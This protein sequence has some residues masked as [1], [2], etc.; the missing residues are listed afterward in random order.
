MA[1]LDDQQ[2][3]ESAS[4]AFANDAL[5]LTIL[6]TERC[7]LRCTYCYERFE[8]GK[9]SGEVVESVKRLLSRRV[10]E[11]RRLAV[12]WF[13]GE[14]LLAM[15]VIEQIS[16]H[17]QRLADQHPDLDYG[18]S[19]TTNGVR[20]SVDVA[21][22]LADVGVRQ[23][24]VSLDGPAE[25][26]DLTRKL[27]GG[28]GSYAQ[29]ERNLLGI[30]DSDIP[31]EISLRVHVTIANVDR[32]ADFTEDLIAKFLGDERFSVYFFPI[33]DLGG[34]NQGDFA[35]L[36][37]ATAT[38][39]VHRLTK[40]VN[41]AR[42]KSALKAKKK[43]CAAHYVCYA[44]KPNAWV[45]RSDGRLAKCTVGFEDE[46]NHIGR[47]LPDGTLDVLTERTRIWLRG[48]STGDA[49]SLQCPYEDMRE[50]VQLG[51]VVSRR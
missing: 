16:G 5:E 2:F 1:V 39:V 7:N 47:L 26:H 8:L 34:P 27:A 23:L 17:A 31:V 13:G 37:Q 50:D 12:D 20:L 40:R 10:P 9:M 11:L 14:P 25:V 51:R 36:D 28:S 30:R 44:A 48:W 43:G 33:V 45:I 15:D 49:L 19:V 38:A 46:R 29:I 4:D 22:R 18:G 32:L 42:P 21:R 24:H 6:P 35:V 41:A 3:W